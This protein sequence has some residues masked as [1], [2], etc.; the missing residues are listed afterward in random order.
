MEDFFD[1]TIITL[2]HYKVNNRSGTLSAKRCRYNDGDL[3]S[4][5]FPLICDSFFVVFSMPIQ[6]VPENQFNAPFQCFEQAIIFN[7]WKR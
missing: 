5:Y 1:P 7:K 3:K 2:F 6:N 4:F